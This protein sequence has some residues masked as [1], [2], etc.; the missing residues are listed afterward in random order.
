MP[1]IY[2][3]GSSLLAVT[4][5]GLTTAVSYSVSGLADWPLASMFI[6]G[7]VLGGLGGTRLAVA[8]S[9]RRRLLTTAFS[10][11]VMRVRVYVAA[12][13]WRAL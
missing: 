1:L 7:G 12:R 9:R 6:L 10:V 2:A 11:V 13:G 3:I 5:F 8:V 4:A